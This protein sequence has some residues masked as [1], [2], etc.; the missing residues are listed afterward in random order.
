MENNE[1][2]GISV[3][4]LFSVNIRLNEDEIVTCLRKTS[5]R[6]KKSSWFQ[7]VLLLLVV[8]NC[9]FSFLTDDKKTFSTLGIAVAALIVVAI[10]WLVP[11]LHNRYI[12]KQEMQSD[13]S[14]L[15]LKVYEDTLVFGNET[16]TSFG[17]TECR[18][19]LCDKLIVLS[20]G[21][22]VVG[23]PRR[24]LSEEEWSLLLVKL[25]LHPGS[26]A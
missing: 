26:G 24:L 23:I 4:P 5:K 11:P 20:I 10:I 8:F 14:E 12:A 22:Q 1:I 13:S 15:K 16:S 19:I 25:K 3:Q 7:T 9:I 6:S 18:P 17:F 21:T 2:Q